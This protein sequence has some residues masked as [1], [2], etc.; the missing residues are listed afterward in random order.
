MNTKN[1]II[2]SLLGAGITTVFSVLPVLN[3]LNFLVCLPFWG[4]P[5]LAAWYY[6]RQTGVLQINHAILIGIV[7][8]IFAG[9]FSFVGMAG[10]LGLASQVK[11]VLPTGILPSDF[12]IGDTAPLF[13]LTSII[14]NILFG[15]IGGAIAGA[16]INKRVF[17]C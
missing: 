6:K 10:G 8:G 17:A 13:T 2:A 16:V 4:G 14:F 11:Q 9:V 5:F 3:L 1:L 7:T 15:A 12:W